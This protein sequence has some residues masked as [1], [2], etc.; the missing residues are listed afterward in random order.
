MLSVG[1][2]SMILLATDACV[3]VRAEF[4]KRMHP[5][6]RAQARLLLLARIGE[7]CVYIFFPISHYDVAFTP[8]IYC[9]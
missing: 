4:K 5:S 1:L 2:R 7:Y 9:R 6:K 3:G 8:Q